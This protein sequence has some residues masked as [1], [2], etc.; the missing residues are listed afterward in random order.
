MV[1]ALDGDECVDVCDRV[2]KGLRVQLGTHSEK[3][4]LSDFGCT[5]TARALTF[6]N[7]C[8]PVP[9]SPTHTASSSLVYAYACV[10]VCVCVCARVCVRANTHTHTHTHSLSLSLSLTH[11]LTHSYI[12]AGT[13][14]VGMEAG[15]SEDI[16][17]NLCALAAEAE[18]QGCKAFILTIPELSCEAD[19][20]QVGRLRTQVNRL[21]LAEESLRT[22]DVAALLPYH[23]A[24]IADRD[25][26]FEPDGLHLRP[27]GYDVIASAV[28]ARLARA[29]ADFTEPSTSSVSGCALSAQDALRT[30]PAPFV[31]Q[32]APSLP[33]LPAAVP[34]ADALP[35][36]FP[37]P[38]PAPLSRTFFLSS[39]QLTHFMA[40]PGFA[41]GPCIPEQCRQRQV[42]DAAISSFR[43]PCFVDPVLLVA[44]HPD[45]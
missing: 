15:S 43:P 40:E 44:A 29:S 16:F 32:P 19:V 17:R 2:W 12:L 27:A 25:R 35:F 31:Y 8:Q 28:A 9:R 22:I 30:L 7:F 6:E 38:L 13:N 14:D 34:D 45:V 36:P 1:E 20:R 24:A 42:S 3:F 41:K 37:T 11:S 39:P 18:T 23:H 10:C 33:L 21:L 5:F 4:S 26:I